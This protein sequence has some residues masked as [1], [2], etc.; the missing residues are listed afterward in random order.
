[1]SCLV[2]VLAIAGAICGA[3]S[4]FLW[5]KA[6]RVQ[7]VPMWAEQGQLEPVDP[8]QA[9]S[10]WIVALIQTATKSGNLNRRAAVWTAWA[11]GFGAA[12]AAVSAV[13]SAPHG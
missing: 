5:Y 6:S 2:S 7:I 9:Q 1:M 3:R 8:M 10:E 13:A 11:T 4:A 12:A